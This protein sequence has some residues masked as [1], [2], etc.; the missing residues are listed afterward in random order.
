MPPRARM[1]AIQKECS[2]LRARNSKL[3]SSRD[4]WKDKA[5]QYEKFISSTAVLYE[6][7]YLKNTAVKKLFLQ[8]KQ[9]RVVASSAGTNTKPTKLGRL[10]RLNPELPNIIVG[11]PEHDD[12]GSD[13]SVNSDDFPSDM[14]SE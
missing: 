6:K 14:S 3:K 13:G 11:D 8:A 2:D 7:Q 12:D 4:R 10:T 9:K 5:L 1:S